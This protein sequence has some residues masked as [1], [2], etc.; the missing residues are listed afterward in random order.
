[1]ATEQP[2]G[3]EAANWFER[4]LGSYSSPFGT[5]SPSTTA[6]GPT[7]YSISQ[8]T[9][10][11]DLFKSSYDYGSNYVVFY[12]N[13]AEES[14]LLKSG[15]EPT[16]EIDA[17]ER[18][19]SSLNQSGV[20]DAAII[21]GSAALGAGFG[22]ILGALGGGGGS[23]AGGGLFGAAIGGAAAGIVT[24]STGGKM[25]RQQKRLQSAIALN[26]PNQLSI[27]YSM[28][29]SE[30]DTAGFQAAATLTEGGLKALEES[31]SNKSANSGSGAGN[32][33]GPAASIATALSLNA[34]GGIG[35][36][37]SVASGLAPNP[38]KEQIFKGVDFRTFTFDYQFAPR[39]S[40]EA[41]NV[42]NIIK[43]FKLHM[44]P[45]FKDTSSFVFIFPSEFDIHYYNIAGDN[46]SIHKHTSCVL[47]D[48]NIN[49]T[50]NAAF[51]TFSDGMPTQINMTMTFKELAI[52]TKDQILMGY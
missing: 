41:R 48:L 10:P 30:T 40:N 5:A 43:M 13:V 14:K 47:T 29:W 11:I 7:G 39:D 25:S 33:T 44:H 32:V 12:I 26:V 31:L 24:A 36:G 37:L 34:P 15:A 46:P 20:S 49:Y 8:Y 52:L 18:L 27:R 1:M 51:T 28:N 38:K 19:R 50:P 22:T 16:V 4:Q 2:V 6:A 23:A 9:Y 3:S 21:S 42:L 35:E 17:N 45:E